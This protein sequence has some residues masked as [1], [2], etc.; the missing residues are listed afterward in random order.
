MSGPLIVPNLGANLLGRIF[1]L[2]DVR[3]QFG[4]PVPEPLLEVDG[5]RLLPLEP[6]LEAQTGQRVGHRGGLFRI[7]RKGGNH[8][9]V[10]RDLGRYAD[11]PGD[12]VEDF[13]VRAFIGSGIRRTRG[14]SAMPK[15]SRLIDRHQPARLRG[16]LGCGAWLN[17]GS[18]PRSRSAMTFPD[19]GARR[20]SRPIDSTTIWSDTVVGLWGSNRSIDRPWG[21]RLADDQQCLR[22]VARWHRQQGGNRQVPRRKR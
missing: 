20:H 6:R 1:M 12:V 10:G 9:S 21:L 4:K 3:P 13:E 19:S 7:R 18:D 8:Y 14:C 17:S 16:I 5:L 22:L 2:P 11:R 15:P